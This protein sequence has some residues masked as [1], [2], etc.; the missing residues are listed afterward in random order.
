[1]HGLRLYHKLA[2]LK[3]KDNCHNGISV[4]QETRVDWSEECS[5]RPNNRQSPQ[6]VTSKEL[7]HEPPCSANVQAP[8]KQTNNNN[9]N[10]NNKK[11]QSYSHRQAMTTV[12]SHVH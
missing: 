11:Q 7:S 1:M 5:R 10:N 8:F 6:K 4:N 2:F 9:N 12:C 3:Q